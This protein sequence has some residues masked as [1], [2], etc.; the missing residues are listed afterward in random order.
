MSILQVPREVGTL[1]PSIVGHIFGIPVANSSVFEW[2]IAIVL[3]F[4]GVF[5]FR[6][7]T[8]KSESKFQTIIEV[9]YESVIGL[10][11]SITGSEKIA[12]RVFPLAG[13]LLIFITVSNYLG[14]IPGLSAITLDGKSL[15]RTATTDFNVTLGLAVGSILIIHATM[16]YDQGFF[17]YVGNFIKIKPVIQGFKKSIGDGG[18]AIVDMLIGLLD[19]IGEFAKVVSLSLRLFGNMYAGEVL[20]TILVGIFAFVVPSAWLAMGVLSS[21]VQAV[22]F[23]A[24]VTVFYTLA[25]KPESQ[26]V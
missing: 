12:K 1:E 9:M 17:G 11:L 10:I 20:M 6:K 8:L 25:M 5:F 13:T 19:I 7:F 15:L 18:L 26:Q 22:V 23:S 2:L 4:L 14:M 16:I 3:V 21:I 24:L